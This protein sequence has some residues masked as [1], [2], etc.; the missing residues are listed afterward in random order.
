MTTLFMIVLILLMFAYAMSRHINVQ[1]K[2]DANMDKIKLQIGS[3]KAERAA[4]LTC[5]ET[6]PFEQVKHHTIQNA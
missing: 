6:C 3:M 4:S 5:G 2:F 1:R